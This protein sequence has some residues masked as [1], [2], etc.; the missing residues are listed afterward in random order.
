[1]QFFDS[2]ICPWQM[3]SLEVNICQAISTQNLINIGLFLI[4]YIEI[5]VAKYL[6]IHIK[7][8]IFGN[9]IGYR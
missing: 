8:L 5:I 2:H 6:I 1:M 3:V 4:L 9:A 7:R